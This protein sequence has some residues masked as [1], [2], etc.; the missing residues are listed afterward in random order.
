MTTDPA[1][2]LWD[3]AVSGRRP[4]NEEEHMLAELHTALGT[5]APLPYIKRAPKH[6]SSRSWWPVAGMVA[7]AAL[8]FALIGALFQTMGPLRTSDDPFASVPP[9]VMGVA[10]PNT[11]ADCDTSKDYPVFQAAN[12]SPMDGTA[13]I[14]T[15]D[16]DLKFTCN[17]TEETLLTG[18]RMVHSS[19]GP[20]NTIL[21]D[22]VSHFTILNVATGE[23]LDF[24]EGVGLDHLLGQN[25]PRLTESWFVAPSSDRLSAASAYNS[26]TMKEYP[27]IDDA[28]ERIEYR[29]IRTSTAS[30]DDQQLTVAVWSSGSL[31]QA[32]MGG[33][34]Q[35]TLNAEGEAEVTFVAVESQS[36]PRYIAV[37]PQGTLV[38]SAS[39]SG[40][41]NDGTVEISI[42]DLETG[43]VGQSWAY[44]AIT[45]APL[46]A[47]SGEGSTLA[48][49]N[50]KALYTWDASGESDPEAIITSNYILGGT[51]TRDPNV[52]AVSAEIGEPAAVTYLIDLSSGS[53]NQLDGFDMFIGNMTS[54][55]TT[56]LLL[57]GK[58][59]MEGNTFT[60]IDA[61]TGEALGTFEWN[62]NPASSFNFTASGEGHGDIQ[63]VAMAWDSA[64]QLV[65]EDGAATLQQIDVPEEAVASGDPDRLIF[66]INDGNLSILLP[67]DGGTWMK[68]ADSD[69]WQQI[70]LEEH[71]G[72]KPFPTLWVRG[73]N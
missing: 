38:A 37:N 3:F 19:Y 73:G 10:S 56:M 29:Q 17:G 8:V 4:E 11:G 5:S 71:D 61:V 47:W 51:F 24:P 43:E 60:A 7:A 35:V 25:R 45:T 33:Y 23:S 18:V 26:A 12:T 62:R 27:L 42:L 72:V 14:A 40:Q 59:G 9:V 70:E 69:E 68:T 30:A 44:P 34:S 1:Q 53:M 52:I 36:E 64:W 63:V 21:V 6:L 41:R 31:E 49:S 54:V 39:Y 57:D 50:G 20:P 55:R 28:G 66:G 32:S 48:F 46:L 16:G 65:D 2:S 67:Y 22:V 58:P 15:L 13:L